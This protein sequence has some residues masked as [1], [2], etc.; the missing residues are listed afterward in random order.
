MKIVKLFAELQANPTP[1]L[2]QQIADHYKN[3]NRPNEA[4]A[5][6]L[7][8]KERYGNSPDCHKEQREDDPQDT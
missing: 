2:Y 5:F 8:I 4:E 3:C 7:L 6:E 1:V